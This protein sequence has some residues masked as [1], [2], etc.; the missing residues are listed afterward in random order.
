MQYTCQRCHS[1]F[2]C[3][4]I[5]AWCAAAVCVFL[6][7]P[8]PSTAPA[9]ELWIGAATADITP[10]RPVPLTGGSSV[11]IAREVLNRCTANVL[12]LESRDGQRALDQAI[13]VSCDLCVIRPGIQ[14]GFRKHLAGRLPG[15]DLNK[16]ILAATHTHA[17]PVILQDRFDEKDY[18]DAMQPKEYVPWM[19]EQMAQAVVKAW[20]GRA[21][22]AVAWG[23]GHAVAGHNR[24]IVYSDGRAKMHGNTS[25]PKFRG[26]EGYEDHGVHILCFYDSDKRLKATAITLATTAQCMGGTKVSADFWHDVR[27]LIH[28]RHG[29]DVCVLG[30]CAPA[31]DQT[32]RTQVHKKAEQR[33]CELRGLTYSQE[34]GRRIANTFDD[35]AAVIAHDIR[36]DVPLVHR[37][38]QIELPARIVTDAEYA[39]AKRVCEKI[40]AKTTLTKSDYWSK[41]LY[42]F[43]AERYLSQQQDG[44]KTFEME[45]HVLRLGDVAIATNPFELFLDYGVQIEARSPAVQTFLI[46][47]ATNARHHGYY[48]PTPRAMAGGA[49]DE[50]P[51]TNYSATVVSNPV[52]PKGGQVLVDRTVEAIQELWK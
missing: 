31:G 42:G 13:L 17:A 45:L 33:M 37:V 21:A 39:V 27:R 16:I 5:V 19:Y 44:W 24:R 20:E 23:L 18:G 43:V 30:F 2:R 36:T 47:L 8:A 35:V 22:G 29:D 25:G 46:Q 7:G 11:R 12:A 14:E 52:G 50:N 3:I 38:Q 28:E 49:L 9:G 34:I 51:F 15:F 48:I 4:V 40:D 1:S 32:P 6:L 41:Y 10:D 26:I